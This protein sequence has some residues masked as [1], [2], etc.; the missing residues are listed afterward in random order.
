MGIKNAIGGIIGFFATLLS[1]S[2]LASIQSLPGKT[3]AI[4][5]MPMYAQQVLSAISLL[6]TIG[7]IVY[8]RLVIA[9]M[10]KVSSPKLDKK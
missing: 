1:S 3:V 5:G 9:P 7:L 2:L 10:K 6:F 8:M 4:L